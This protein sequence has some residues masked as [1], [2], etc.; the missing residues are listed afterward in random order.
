MVSAIIRPC[1]VNDLRQR[2]LWNAR[3]L[4]TPHNLQIIWSEVVLGQLW[5]YDNS[6]TEWFCRRIYCI[7]HRWHEI[8]TGEKKGL[9]VLHPDLFRKANGYASWYGRSRYCLLCPLSLPW[10][11]I[12]AYV[13]G[14]SAG[15]NPG[16]LTREQVPFKLT[17]SRCKAHIIRCTTVAPA[18]RL[19]LFSCLLFPPVQRYLQLAGWRLWL[20]CQ[21]NEY[22]LELPLGLLH[23]SQAVW[24]YNI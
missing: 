3:R 19:P 10:I 5:T 8:C 22:E 18:F 24:R 7:G 23:S 2:R 11:I 20:S 12:S 14:I 1:V 15:R 16:Y 4:I 17:K 13:L 6:L 9:I 21:R